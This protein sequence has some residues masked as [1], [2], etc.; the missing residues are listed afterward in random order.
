MAALAADEDNAE[1]AVRWA[2][3][4]LAADPRAAS[5]YYTLGRVH[6]AE[7]RLEEAAANYRDSITLDSEQAGAHNNLGCVLQMQGRLDE[8]IESFRRALALDPALPQANQNLASI[9][10]DRAALEAAVAGYRRRARAN[11]ADAHV[12][13]DLGNVYREIGQ[14]AEAMACF[15][16]ALSRAPDFAQ[17]HYSR[18]Q[19]ALLLGDFA[20]GWE[21]HEWRWKVKG[22]KLDM[23]DFPQPL[24]GG[25][26]LPAGTLL[27][28]AEQGLGDT[29]QF[30]RY[31]RLAARR[32][33]GVV[34]QCQPQLAGLLRT[35]PGPS[36][37]VPQG[38]ALPAFD[39]HLPLMSLPWIF[40]TTPENI[41][42]DGPYL[43]ADQGRVERWRGKLTRDARIH[44]GVV[45]AGRPQQS[46]DRK[47]STRL[48]TLAALAQ[49][50][51]ALYSLQ[52]GEA[53]AQAATP[54]PGMRITGFG[55]EIRDF[56]ETAALLGCLDVV[57]TVDT[58]MAHLA[59]AM[60]VPAWVLLA[61][62][63]EWRWLLERHDSPWYPTMRLFRQD[64]DGDWSGPVR[65]IADALAG[66][67]P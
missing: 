9:T 30:A 11:P 41:P 56:S 33:R 52:W 45:W 7:G 21:D 32:C 28:H 60:G 39:A 36:L 40:R 19:T 2:K 67:K 53:A 8:A 46:D 50:G 24:W 3:R 27:L 57:V 23:P 5:A 4:A 66:L 43:F 65:R 42:W 20:A 13:N 10:R 12:W 54:P 15:A 49:P 58:A 16:E 6:Q 64:T 14:P 22:L 25:G 62:A 37:V 29:I 38:D 44:V 31:A 63:P 47:R 61:Q 18:G 55:D 35:M 48:A 1:E 34:L 26:A 59:G 17:A 51:V